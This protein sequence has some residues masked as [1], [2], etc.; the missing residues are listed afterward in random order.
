MLW[1]EQFLSDYYFIMIFN[2]MSKPENEEITMINII[3]E[4]IDR[5]AKLKVKRLNDAK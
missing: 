1:Q 3:M 2:P 4:D 5:L